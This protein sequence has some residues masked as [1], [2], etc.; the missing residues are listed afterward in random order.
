MFCLFVNYRCRSSRGENLDCM[1]GGTPTS[2]TNNSPS[3]VVQAH[4][5]STM[6]MNGGGSGG[7]RSQHRNG[8]NGNINREHWNKM[9]EQQHNGHGLQV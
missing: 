1:G 6:E 9:S 7:S 8:S 4:H 2:V 5:H 3:A